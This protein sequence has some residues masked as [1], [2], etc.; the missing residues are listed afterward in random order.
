MSMTVGE[1]AA[2]VDGRVAGD[3]ILVITGC[4]SIERA[5]ASDLV[6]VDNEKHFE[7]ARA[8]AAGAI[9]APE[10]MSAEGKTLII[11]NHP[12]LAFAR[13]LSVMAAPPAETHTIHAS[14]IIDGS[15]E[16]G[17][18]VAVAP[19]AVIGARTRIGKNSSI[20]AGT[21]IGSDVEIGADC[22]IH[23][24]VTIYDRVKLRDRVIVHA[25]TVIGSDGFGYVYHEG[26]YHKFPQVG[27][28]LIE[29][30]VEIGSNVSIDRGA[31]DTTLI[32]RGT[33]ID[34]LV[35]VGHN[36]RIGENCVM[37]AQVGISG[38]AVIEDNAVLGGQVGVADHVKIERGAI[39]GAQA[40]IPSG[41]IIRR[42][43][44]VW[45]TPAR[46]IDEFKHIYAH[47]QHLPALKAR[48]VELERRLRDITD[49]ENK[50]G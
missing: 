39:I 49:S 2:L 20:G 35:Q 5:T 46:P 25:N 4:A 37:A 16:I 43:L 11:V 18:N 47:T 22:R 17:E 7:R 10:R 29:E 45:G 36:V 14:A 31:L 21:V 12:K 3:E 34:N 8:C 24:N 44:T 33:K 40:G 30:D 15:A 42:G 23:A 9:V 41:K 38:S 13:I 48:I 50:Q 32:S 27:D 28:V 26:R 1:L 19:Y 6:F